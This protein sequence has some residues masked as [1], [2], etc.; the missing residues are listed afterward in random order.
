MEILHLPDFLSF[1]HSILSMYVLLC[2]NKIEVTVFRVRCFC[3]VCVICF[4]FILCTMFYI[5]SRLV[6]LRNTD[7][8]NIHCRNVYRR[9]AYFNILWSIIYFRSIFT[10]SIYLMVLYIILL[11]IIRLCYFIISFD[12]VIIH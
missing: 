12:S 2:G 5:L 11:L 9:I 6:N 1:I 3:S 4:N 10:L 8:W 7:I